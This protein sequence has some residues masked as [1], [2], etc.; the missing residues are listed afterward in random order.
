MKKAKDSNVA[1]KIILLTIFVILF[2][3]V[4]FINSVFLAGDAISYGKFGFI[5][6]II[7]SVMLAAAFVALCFAM[8]NKKKRKFC[9]TI[10]AALVIFIV[11]ILFLA[12]SLVINIEYKTFD[13]EKWKNYNYVQ[14]RQYMI[15]DLE[16]KHKIVGMK[17]YEAKNLLGTGTDEK[18]ADGSHRITYDVGV[19]GLWHMTYVL[20]YDENG[21]ITKTYTTVD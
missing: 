5:G 15:D 7:P 1:I 21:I 10:S 9:V 16:E 13:S 19:A 14:G 11:P 8:F 17:T 4:Y 6:K 2:I 20:E 12:N 3:A 18:S